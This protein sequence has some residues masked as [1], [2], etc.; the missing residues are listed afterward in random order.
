MAIGGVNRIISVWISVCGCEKRDQGQRIGAS[1]MYRRL[2]KNWKNDGIKNMIQGD[3]NSEGCS[4]CLGKMRQDRE[5][6][7]DIPI[8]NGIFQKLDFWHTNV[9]CVK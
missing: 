6:F 3:Q 4:G 1:G 2:R 8:Q 7:R 5:N 9:F